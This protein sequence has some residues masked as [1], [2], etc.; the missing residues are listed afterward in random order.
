M[1]VLLAS[2]LAIGL[3]GVINFF[4]EKIPVSYGVIFFT[5]LLIAVSSFGGFLLYLAPQLQDQAQEYNNIINNNNVLD[6][7]PQFTMVEISESNIQTVLENN[8]SKIASE[9][10]SFLSISLTL[11]TYF[12]VAILIIMYGAWNYQS[13]NKF[14][15]E[16][17]SKLPNKYTLIMD[18]VIKNIRKWLL[19][20]FLSMLA[21][22]LLT[23][24][25]LLVLGVQT[26]LLL[27]LIAGLLSF[28][29]NI[30]PVLS[31]IPAVI[32]AGSTGWTLVFLVASLY[33]FIQIVE[34][35]FITPAVQKKMV[36]IPP[37]LL[38]AMQVVGG[39]VF[40]ILGLILAGPVTAVILALTKT[41]ISTI[42]DH[43]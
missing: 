22:G 41:K 25:G 42:P 23:Y 29:P 8:I 13:Y 34:S 26:P 11:F 16:I 2:I 32:V 7:V 33:T 30:G 12:F 14:R 1:L 39:S 24:I 27:A 10:G 38:L 17:Q 6:L 5:I 36:E 18:T 21:V 43:K 28:I 15:E 35:Y 9:F 3:V 19:G 20:R 4:T 37:A 31:V 40:G